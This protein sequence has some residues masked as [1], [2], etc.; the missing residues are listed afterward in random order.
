MTGAGKFIQIEVVC[1]TPER[2]CLLALEVAVGVTA[3]AA[4]AATDIAD[5]FPE[6]DFSTC[7]LGVFGRQVNDDYI[8]SDGDRVEVYRLLANEP[9]ASRLARAATKADS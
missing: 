8:L 3:R 1:A 9:Q 4:I 2:Q 5:R 6:I 7:A